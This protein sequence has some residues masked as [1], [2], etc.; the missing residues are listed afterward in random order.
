MIPLGWPA[1]RAGKAEGRRAERVKRL[2]VGPQAHKEKLIESRDQAGPRSGRAGPKA[3]AR[4]IVVWD[5][6]RLPP[7]GC[8]SPETPGGPVESRRIVWL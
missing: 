8:V 6:G 4:S 5:W 7:F 1:K 2:G 3:V